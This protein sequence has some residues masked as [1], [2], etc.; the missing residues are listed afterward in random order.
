M[1]KVR[2]VW[3]TNVASNVLDS[4]N[5][6]KKAMQLLAKTGFNVIFPVVWNKGFTLYKSEVME[7][8][9]GSD[10]KI[11][12]KYTG[13]DPLQE[14]INA[15]K[16]VGLKV[17]PWFE[18][19]FAASYVEITMNPAEGM[20]EFGKHILEQKPEFSAIDHSGNELIKPS[21]V[22]HSDPEKRN[23]QGFKWM[24]ALKPEVQDFMLEL[25]LEVAKKYD[26]D[27]IQGDDRLP[28]FPV[29]GFDQAVANNFSG[30]GSRPSHTNRDWMQ[31]RADILTKYLKR[32]KDEVKAVGLSKGKELIVS[33]APHPRNHG[34]N[35]A[36][37]DTKKWLK[38]GLVD[39][40]HPQLY[41]QD[42][43]KYKELSNNE[44]VGQGFTND[45]LA[46]ISPGIL[47]K[48]GDF[49]INS[50]LL[51]KVIKHNKSL[52][53]NGVV[54]FFFEGLRIP[55]NKVA[56]VLRN[57]IYALNSLDDEG[58]DVKKIQQLLKDKGFDVPTNGVFD[59]DTKAA[60]EAFQIAQGFADRDIDGIVGPQTLEKLGI[61]S[62]IALGEMP[63]PVG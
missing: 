31:F 5:N 17:I 2:G 26:V 11:D 24:N 62:L 7:R 54:F 52:G 49:R 33:M 19:G 58:P 32:I 22:R 28:A 48:L 37:Q 9:F 59:A 53:I 45:E 60:V 42:F 21:L 44:I 46:K 47:M 10:F 20:Q 15:A 40:S 39:M 57:D 1:K 56:Q 63:L 6:I 8:N 23:L 51:E 18:Y 35:T 41:R 36:L 13:R 61:N 14:V 43:D 34:F 3:V 29:E 50:D 4:E 30:I 38:N 16:E 12:P 25:I 55:D 27:G